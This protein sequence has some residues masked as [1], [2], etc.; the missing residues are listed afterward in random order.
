MFNEST[1]P[2]FLNLNSKR[3]LPPPSSL[4]DTLP[5][6]FVPHKTGSSITKLKHITFVCVIH[7]TTPDEHE[8]LSLYFTFFDSF[9]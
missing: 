9:C 8:T 4:Q 7:V 5:V 6:S 2:S 3:N 1:V